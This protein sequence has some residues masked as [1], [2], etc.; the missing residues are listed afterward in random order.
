[1]SDKGRRSK[2]VARREDIDASRGH[3]ATVRGIKHITTPIF[4]TYLRVLRSMPSGL[5]ERW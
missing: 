5:P 4:L 2:K 1:M 3:A